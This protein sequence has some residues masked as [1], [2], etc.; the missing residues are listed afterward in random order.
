MGSLIQSRGPGGGSRLSNGISS[1]GTLVGAPRSGVEVEARVVDPL[2][3]D[4]GKNPQESVGDGAQ[5]R[6]RQV[7]VLEL[8][9]LEDVLEDGLD[10]AADLERV[11]LGQGAA[12]GFH[13]V[14]E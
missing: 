2:M 1:R 9:V 8:P 14:R 13:R 6:E 12:G 5:V 10:Q 4:V 3:E 11:R 7:G